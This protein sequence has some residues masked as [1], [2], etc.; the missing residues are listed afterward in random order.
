ML[1][2]SSRRLV[3]RS[4]DQSA[5]SYKN[6]LLQ[7]NFGY[8][9]STVLKK[10]QLFRVYHDKKLGND[11]VTKTIFSIDRCRTRTCSLTLAWETD[12]RGTRYHC[13]KRP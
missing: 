3:D 7:E 6:T 9:T 5:E 11:S 13:A 10:D 8:L 2:K 4:I 1:I 12:R